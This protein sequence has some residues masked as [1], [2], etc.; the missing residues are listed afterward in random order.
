MCRSKRLVG[1]VNAAR[2]L[3]A[4]SRCRLA[5]RVDLVEPLVLG[6]LLSDILP[7]HRLIPAHGDTKYPRAQKCC[8]TKFLFFSPYTRARRIVLFPLINPIPCGTAYLVGSQSSCAR[9]RAAS[10]PL[11]SG[12]PSSPLTCGTPSRNCRRNSSYN[13]FLQPLGMNT[14]WYLHS[15]RV[16]LRLPVSSIPNSLS[17]ALAAHLWGVFA[18]D[19]G[20]CQTSTASPAERGVSPTYWQLAISGS[21]AIECRRRQIGSLWNRTKITRRTRITR[22]Q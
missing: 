21:L 3:A 8:P 13:A 11:R 16:W 9:G 22:R 17:C 10:A 19:S 4:P 15:H 20:I 5:P 12:S 14:T 2:K 1:V 18:M 6:L 7:D